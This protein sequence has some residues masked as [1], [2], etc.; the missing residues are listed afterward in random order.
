MPPHPVA[1]DPT[2]QPPRER[3]VIPVV[4]EA[5]ERTEVVRDTP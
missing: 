5:D 1:P 3:M 4:K 2:I